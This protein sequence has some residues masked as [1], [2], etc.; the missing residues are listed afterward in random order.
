V[1][2]ARFDEVNEEDLLQVQR[3]VGAPEPHPGHQDNVVHKVSVHLGGAHAIARERTWVMFAKVN[4][5]SEQG[6]DGEE[7]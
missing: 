7:R 2:Y 3:T 1:S 4:P 6:G 5:T